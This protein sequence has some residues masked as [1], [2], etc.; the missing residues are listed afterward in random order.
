M[1]IVLY[2]RSYVEQDMKQRAELGVGEE[3]APVQLTSNS[4]LSA[5]GHRL[6][7]EYVQAYLRHVYPALPE[8]GIR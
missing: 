5:A 6:A 4:E 2:S 3:E 7:S 1:T 8:E